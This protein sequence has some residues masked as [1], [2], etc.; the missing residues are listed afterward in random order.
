MF[1]P[2]TIASPAPGETPRGAVSHAFTAPSGTRIGYDAY[3]E[4]PPLALIHGGFSDHRTNWTFVKPLLEPH[5]S[6][7]ALARRGRGATD[8]TVGHSLED[9]VEDAVALIRRI[10]TPVFLLGH[11]YGAHVALGAATKVPNLVRKLV[12]YEAPWPHL[13][14]AA[15]M[16]SLEAL[17]RAGDWDGFATMFFADVLAVPADILQALRSTDDWAAILHDAPASLGDLR[18]VSRL[19]FEPERYRSLS[20]PVLLQVGSDS[21]SNFYVTDALVAVLPNASVG[22]LEG[23]AHEGMTTAPEQYVDAIRR[24]L[25]A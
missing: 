22:G 1:A 7:H 20:M 23:Q 10:G 19:D 9:E 12:L 17:F 15:A 25:E 21:P 13:L 2:D 24:F 5:F 11:S 8:A 16:A 6:V 3:G 4:G 18:A 14:G